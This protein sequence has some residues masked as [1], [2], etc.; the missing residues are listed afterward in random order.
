M[1]SSPDSKWRNLI[2]YYLVRLLLLQLKQDKF[3]QLCEDD[4]KL[5]MRLIQRITTSLSLRLR[6]TSTMLSDR[7]AA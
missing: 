3:E 4:P 1:L 5:A 7:L 2:S 6:D